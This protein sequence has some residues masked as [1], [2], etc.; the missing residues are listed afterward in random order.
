MNAAC[1]SYYQVKVYLQI[2]EDKEM[3]GLDE[4]SGLY[5]LKPNGLRYI[6]AYAEIRELLAA[7]LTSMV[8]PKHQQKYNF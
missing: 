4:R 2:L 7:D 1:L 3:V 6:K 5:F 8:V